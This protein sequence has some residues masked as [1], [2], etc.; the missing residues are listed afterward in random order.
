MRAAQRSVRCSADLTD[1]ERARRAVVVTV[2]ALG[3]PDRTQEGQSASGQEQEAADPE[4]KPGHGRQQ[5]DHDGDHAADHG[6]EER[7][8]HED[9]ERPD[10]V[11]AARA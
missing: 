8:E 4:L 9:Q 11:H 7:T 1:I 3:R 6:G 10:D 2:A 5:V